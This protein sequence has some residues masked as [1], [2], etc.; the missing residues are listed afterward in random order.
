MKKILWG[1]VIIGLVNII[2]SINNSFAIE[3]DAEKYYK[4]AEDYFSKG[5]YE[6]LVD[7]AKKA[8]DADPKYLDAYY[9]LGRGYL[10]LKKPKEAVEIFEK[11]L[12]ID[13]K[14]GD[15]Y[16]GLGEIYWREEEDYQKAINAFKKA[17]EVEPNNANNRTIYIALAGI[18]EELKLYNEC[19]SALEKAKSI[20]PD[21]GD[22]YAGFGD[23]YNKLKQFDKAKENYNKAIV[24]YRNEGLVDLAQKYEKILN[25]V[26]KPIVRIYL[27]SHCVATGKIIEETGEYLN[28]EGDIFC[29][30]PLDGFTIGHGG[31]NKYNKKDIERIEEIKEYGVLMYE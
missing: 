23:Y 27:K 30:A 14:S 9:G 10:L 20:D 26:G 15:A 19:L 1:F 8:I 21:Y 3:S 24:I 18:Y 2:F 4:E 6:K 16:M 11:M 17:L 29:P 5:E 25:K 12:T 7:Y 28:V 13:P 22:V 31:E